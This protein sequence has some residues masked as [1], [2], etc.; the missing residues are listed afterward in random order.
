MYSLGCDYCLSALT[1]LPS[2]SIKPSTFHF[3][4]CAEGDMTPKV[5]S[6]L[7]KYENNWNIIDASNPTCSGKGCQ[8]MNLKRKKLKEAILLRNKCQAKKLIWSTKLLYDSSPILCLT[9]CLAGTGWHMPWEQLDSSKIQSTSVSYRWYVDDNH[10]LFKFLHGL[11][12]SPWTL[13]IR[14]QH[15]QI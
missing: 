11:L 7:K 2:N 6:I 5:T 1:F 8:N 4:P 12:W 3:K 14:T 13:G 15:N 10:C 9:G